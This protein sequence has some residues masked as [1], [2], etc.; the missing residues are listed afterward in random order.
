MTKHAAPSIFIGTYNMNGCP[1]SVSDAQKWLGCN[2]HSR[3]HNNHRN[4]NASGGE[5]GAIVT[6]AHDADL[7]IISLQE[8]P[9]HPHP[10]MENEMSHSTSPSSR[11]VGFPCIQTLECGRATELSHE[12]G[13]HSDMSTARRIRGD[14]NERISSSIAVDSVRDSIASVLSSV[15]ALIA[16]IA[17]GE[18][19]GSV[20]HD[21]GS[22]TKWYGYIRLIV[23]AKTSLIQHITEIGVAH[24]EHSATSGIDIVE[25]AAKEDKDEENLVIPIFA[26]AGRKYLQ[27]MNVNTVSKPTCDTNE[28]ESCRQRSPDK[29]GVC[30]VIPSLRLLVCSL[31]LCGTNTY[32]TPEST[33]DVIRLQELNIIV[34]ECRRVIMKATWAARHEH[35]DH[36]KREAPC[37]SVLDDFQT[38]LCGDLNLRVEVCEDS[39]HKARGGEEFRRVSELIRTERIKELFQESDRLVQLLRFLSTRDVVD[40]DRRH[41]HI[42]HNSNCNITLNG[43]YSKLAKTWEE[44]IPILSNETVTFLMSLTDTFMEHFLSNIND[45]GEEGLS[46]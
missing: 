36:P 38:I 15:H 39:Q 28:K 26:P 24:R 35:G 10:H 2:R 4:G 30:L 7:V 20:H 46:M 33:F 17:M 32:H 27:H 34:E 44:L 13:N 18:N 6:S 9:T 45:K 1:L 23:F 12:V 11:T 43:N 42:L 8:C 21:D 31:H 16:D 14:H 3:V 29:G 41:T 40:V 25:D 37:V 19:A 22:T 5:H